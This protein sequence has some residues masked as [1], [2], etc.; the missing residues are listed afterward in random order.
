[1]S[2]S[3][4]VAQFIAAYLGLGAV[5]S[6]CRLEQIVK[7][8]LEFLDL[9]LEIQ[10]QFGHTIPDSVYGELKTVGD[11]ERVLFAVPS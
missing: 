3:G 7:D 10:R 11:I 4:D 2:S 1:M 8:S 5:D 6:T 9:M